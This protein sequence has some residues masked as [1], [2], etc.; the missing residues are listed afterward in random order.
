M[1]ELGDFADLRRDL[2][3]KKQR[4]VFYGGIDTSMHTMLMKGTSGYYQIL[5]KTLHEKT[6]E[7]ST[8][9]FLMNEAD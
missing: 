3:K 1:E 5:Y 4:G 8:S 6:T 2:V 7:Y 9:T